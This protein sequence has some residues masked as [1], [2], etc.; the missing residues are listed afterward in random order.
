MRTLAKITLLA[1]FSLGICPQAYPAFH[2]SGDPFAFEASIATGLG[3]TVILHQNSST[4]PEVSSMNFGNLVE[5]VNPVTGGKTL[6]SSTQGSTGTGSIV[7][8]I[9]PAASGTNVPYHVDCSGGSLVNSS[10]ATLPTGA[11]IVTPVYSPEDNN[12]GAG[13]VPIAGTLGAGGSWVVAS[14]GRRIFTSNAAADYRAI[15]AHFAITDDTAAGATQAV[16]INQPGGNY[17]GT[18]VFTITE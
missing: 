17:Q 10:G 16:P 3:I 5:F 9:Y 13:G 18:V 15:Q 12:F 6:R 8:M 1:F 7:A 2:S 4:G 11:C 14:P